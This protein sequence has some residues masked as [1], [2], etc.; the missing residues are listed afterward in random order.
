M[1]DDDRLYDCLFM[2]MDDRLKTELATGSNLLLTFRFCS[3][4]LSV[5]VSVIYPSRLRTRHENFTKF[6]TYA[7]ALLTALVDSEAESSI[8][9][10]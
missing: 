2:R 4:R 6:L 3:V 8:Y 7:V 1:L 5:R 10:V 9:N